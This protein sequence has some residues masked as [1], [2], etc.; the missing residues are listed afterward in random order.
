[1]SII[2]EET[3]W[4][5]RSKHFSDTKTALV[6]SDSETHYR[7]CVSHQSSNYW[8]YNPSPKTRKNPRAANTRLKLP[9]DT[10]DS[11]AAGTIRTYQGKQATHYRPE[12][13][14][15]D[16]EDAFSS[17]DSSGSGAVTVK[18]RGEKYVPAHEM[19]LGS[20]ISEVRTLVLETAWAPRPV[21]PKLLEEF[22]V[23]DHAM[24]RGCK[25]IGEAVSDHWYQYLHFR[26]KI[27]QLPQTSAWRCT[28]PQGPSADD[29]EQVQK[30]YCFQQGTNRWEFIVF[31]V[32]SLFR[33]PNWINHSVM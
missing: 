33:K 9:T 10:D 13:I 2:L 12:K 29:H 19:N 15:Y 32:V 28:E 1:M 18:N 17:C 16:Q 23:L 21:R 8:K 24:A 14:P 22:H 31:S 11:C 7:T 6:H 4:S 26:C 5:P 25:R 30:Q 27:M 3:V 20:W